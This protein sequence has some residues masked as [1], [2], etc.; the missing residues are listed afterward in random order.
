MGGCGSRNRAR[1]MNLIQVGACVCWSGLVLVSVVVWVG[2]GRVRGWG[3]VT[4]PG[5]G[6]ETKAHKCVCLLV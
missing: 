5:E 6:D 2:G 4:C 3:W 1:L